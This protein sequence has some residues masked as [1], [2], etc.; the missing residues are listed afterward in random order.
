MTKEWIL[1]VLPFGED[2]DL[3]AVAQLLPPCIQVGAL[4]GGVSLMVTT[5]IVPGLLNH[6]PVDQLDCDSPI[7]ISILK[8]KN[9]SKANQ[10]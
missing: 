8:R 2:P 6:I 3:A 9:T 4:V 5:M 10:Y 7:R 1:G